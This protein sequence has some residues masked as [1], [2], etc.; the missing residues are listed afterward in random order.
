MD[1][2]EYMRSQ[3]TITQE[4]WECTF[5]K[6]AREILVLLAGGAGAGKRNG[7]WDVSH[8][9]IAYVDC[10]TGALHTGDGRIVYPV[11]DEEHD[12]GGILEHFRREAVYRLKARKKI[13]HEVPEGVTASWRNQFLIV[14]VLEENASC[15][16]L[17]EVLADYRRPVVVTDEVLGEL[18]LDKDL[19]M[20]EGEVL[21]RG[22]Q[23]C[24]S[25]E[26]D[27]A[28]E[29]TWADARRAMTVML[30]EQDRWDRDMR[31]SA[32]RELTELACE[33][34]ESADEEVPEITEESF[35][36]RIE[37]RSIAMDAD[38]SFSAYFDDD[39]MFFGHCVTAYGTLTDGVTAANMEG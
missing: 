39:D 26:V 6:D 36:R 14:E 20:F 29:D 37:L 4:E 19:D 15:P 35:A 22:E 2:L 12:A 16:A 32:A 17:E 7:F 30:A 9:F 23:I 25:L 10:Q 5:E 8:Y 1:L 24:V 27:A 11:S 33:W 18:T 21:W 31:A 28:D 13:P 3:D 38:G 34:R